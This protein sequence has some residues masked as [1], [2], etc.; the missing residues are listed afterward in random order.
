M[1]DLMKIIVCQYNLNNIY[2][3]KISCM[4]MI[5]VSDFLKPN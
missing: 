1:V 2:S 3:F 4:K 5:S